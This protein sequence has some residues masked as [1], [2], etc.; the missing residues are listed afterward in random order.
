M[1]V[2]INGCFGGFGLSTEAEVAFL[3]RK[4]KK[5]FFYIEDRGSGPV[6]E[7]DYVRVSAAE[8]KT[9]FI[10]YTSTIDLGE[11][12]KSNVLFDTESAY[13]CGSEIDRSDPDLAA[14]V[15]E[16][17]DKASGP[18]AALHV[19]EIPDGVDYEVDEYDGVES[20]HE[21]HRRWA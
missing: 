18:F 9:A 3:A 14:V 21:K 10:H 17:G 6:M 12:I 2:V 7:C 11:R 8:A 19:V 13:F 16:L 4:G 1:K 15:E 5:A 20:I